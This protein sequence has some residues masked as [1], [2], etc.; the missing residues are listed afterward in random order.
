MHKGVLNKE[1]PTMASA[2]TTPVKLF[3]VVL[4]KNYVPIG[5]YEIVGYL[6]EAVKRKDA[7]GNWRVIEPEEFI[8]GEMKPHQTP[9][10]GYG[11]IEKDGK[12]LVN[13]KIWAGTQ[14][15]LPLDEAKQVVSKKIAERADVIAA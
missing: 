8:K 4:S 2:E 3:P 12:V 13:A 9:G 1:I 5:D 10:V 14:I 7:A 11:A 15:K 6:K